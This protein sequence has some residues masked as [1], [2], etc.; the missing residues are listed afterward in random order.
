MTRRIEDS[1]SVKYHEGGSVSSSD[2]T[3]GFV[4]GV[5]KISKNLNHA[6]EDVHY[7]DGLKYNFLSVSQ[8][9]DKENEVKFMPDKCTVTSFRNSETILT[10]WRS[11]NMYVIDLGSYN[12]KN[13]TCLSTQDDA[14]AL[15]QKKYWDM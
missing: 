7:V 11:K 1:L 10:T 14:G 12:A 2:G 6:I 4:L 3:K 13:L 9:C 8:M 5:G 15:W